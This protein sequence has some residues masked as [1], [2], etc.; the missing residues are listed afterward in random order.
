MRATLIDLA[1]ILVLGYRADS[2][3][4]PIGVIFGTPILEPG[5]LNVAVY[6]LANIL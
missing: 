6:S 2:A 1:L 4:D 3:G 5:L